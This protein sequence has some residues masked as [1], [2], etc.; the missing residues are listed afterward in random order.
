MRRSLNHI[1]ND[2]IDVL[3]GITAM[4]IEVFT[5]F[6]SGLLDVP[7]STPTVTVGVKSA[8]FNTSSLSAFSG[9]TDEGD[10]FST[11]ADIELST[12][13]FLPN[14]A[15]GAVNFEVLSL[16]VFALQK[17]RIPISLV[18]CGTLYYDARLMCSVLPVSIT[19]CE[20]LYS[21][22]ED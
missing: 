4:D 7:I 6:Q 21:D 5:S 9:Y 16:I 20:H 22:E 3:S 1:I 2:V 10:F 8:A 19:L 17:S 18:R 12:N 13:I 14:A 11:K 15:H